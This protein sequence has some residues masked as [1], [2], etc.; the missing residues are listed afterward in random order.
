[1]KGFISVIIPIYNTIMQLGRYL[2]SVL[3]IHINVL[4]LFTLM[5]EAH[6][7]QSANT[8]VRK[9]ESMVQDY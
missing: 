9:I 7:Q 4:K 3:T 2:G 5:M 1:M 8:G 6:R